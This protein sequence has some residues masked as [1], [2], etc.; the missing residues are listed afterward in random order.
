MM[1][2]LELLVLSLVGG[3][4]IVF[5]AVAGIVQGVAGR[6]AARRTQEPRV[7]CN[8]GIA[9]SVLGTFSW[10]FLGYVIASQVDYFLQ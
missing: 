1:D 3:A 4:V 5:F 8:A 7:L 2:R 9:V 6:L 10:L